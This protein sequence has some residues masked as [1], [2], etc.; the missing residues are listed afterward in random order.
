MQSNSKRHLLTGVRAPVT[1][2]IYI[3]VKHSSRMRTV[4]FPCVMVHSHLRFIRRE[5]LRELFSPRN[6]KN[7]YITHY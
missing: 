2:V 3:V 7:G 1:V 5:L 4:F 6:R